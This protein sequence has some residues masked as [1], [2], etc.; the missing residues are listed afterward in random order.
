M[1]RKET[2]QIQKAAKKYKGDHNGWELW[3]S[4]FYN[5]FRAELVQWCKLDPQSVLTYANAQRNTLLE[6]GVAIVDTWGADE[7][8]K[9]M[10]G[11]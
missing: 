5:G 1:V 6:S 11:D 4:E 3:V 9:L 10:V 2:G 7:L 8:A